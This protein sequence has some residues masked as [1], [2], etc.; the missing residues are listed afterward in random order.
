LLLAA[1]LFVMEL[2]IA[3]HGVLGAAGLASLLLGSIMLF[4]TSKTG[5]SIDTDV[6]WTTM[7]GVGSF[8][9]AII[10]LVTR[11][12]L[13]SPK[14]GVEALI[15]EIGI[16]RKTVG[17]RSGK[18]FLHGELWTAVSDE[19]IPVDTE[20]RVIGVDGLKLRVSMI[21]GGKI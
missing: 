14:S 13:S 12:T 21:H 16:V 6:L 5:V 18:V 4:D 15:G 10:Y 11:A 8:L 19:T 1:L 20:V 7:L 9:A 17:M 3:S 2:I